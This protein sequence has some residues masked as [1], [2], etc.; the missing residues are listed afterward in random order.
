MPEATPKNAAE[1]KAFELS[2]ILI[3]VAERVRQKSLRERIETYAISLL[4]NAAIGNKAGVAESINV[5]E[6]LLHIGSEMGEIHTESVAVIIAELQ[7]VN[8]A[9]A[10]LGSVLPVPIDFKID[11]A[12]KREVRQR[13]NRPQNEN[14]Q[15]EI[16]QIIR[17]KGSC[18][19]R[20]IQEG[21]PDVSE[22]TIRYDLG[23]MTEEG[24]IE[25]VGAGGPDTFYRIREKVM[26]VVDNSPTQM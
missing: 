23:R 13:V 11:T 5:L 18:R 19:F 14:R 21:L 15:E 17:Q 2:Y 20:D 4:E 22:R 9:I 1:K 10:G 6:Y 7:K 26:Q 12:K 8:T 24:V 3:R 16:L 25:R